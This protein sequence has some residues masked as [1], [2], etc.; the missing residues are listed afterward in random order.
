MKD[1]YSF[2]HTTDEGE[3]EVMVSVDG[4]TWPYLVDNF[5]YFLRGC[6]F[7]INKKEFVDYFASLIEDWEEAERD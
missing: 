5:F 6:S 3:V 4:P 2:K 7:P 1:L